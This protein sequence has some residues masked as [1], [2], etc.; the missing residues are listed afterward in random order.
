[1]LTLFYW[2]CCLLPAVVLGTPPEALMTT[3]ELIRAH[4][5]PCETH[6]VETPDNFV[7]ALHRIPHGRNGPSTS[8]IS[9]GTIVMQ[10]G[11][12]ADSSDWV[13]N[14]AFNSYGFVAADLN[15]DVWLLNSRGNRYSTNNTVLKPSQKE[16]WDWSW[17]EMAKYDV[18]SSIE[19]I[20]SRNPSSKL[21][22]FAGSQGTTL[23]W[24][25]LS[26][27]PSFAAGRIDLF[28]AFGPVAY[29]FHTQDTLLR[30]ASK[31]HIGALLAELGYYD[32][33]PS[34]AVERDWLTNVCKHIPALCTIVADELAGIESSD[35]NQTRLPVY[36]GHFPSGTRYARD[37]NHCF[38]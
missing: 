17:D 27:D 21:A 5:F 14:E 19:Y 2:A 3:P 20:R 33:L 10:H 1:M 36:F 30:D 8:G 38:V 15:Y 28:V 26:A 7:L 11:L 32:F 16:F 6:Y 4:G 35:L 12:L 13:L 34:K 23:L 22:Y 29:V 24:S 25:H 18:P 37:L 9:R 31:L